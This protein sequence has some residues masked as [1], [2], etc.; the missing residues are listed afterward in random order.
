MRREDLLELCLQYLSRGVSIDEVLASHPEAAEL[1]PLLEAAQAAASLASSGVPR[2]ALVRSR[3]RMLQRAASLRSARPR[4]VGSAW[5]RPAL[6]AVLAAIAISFTGVG[7]AAA[8]SLPG[9]SL[10]AAKTVVEDV[11]LRLASSPAERLRLEQSYEARRVSEIRRLLALGRVVPVDFIGL[12]QD[13]TADSIQVSDIAVRLSPATLLEGDLLVGT[14][15]EVRGTT[16]TDGVVLA[17]EVR[18]KAFDLYGVIDTIEP[19]AW[20]I[21]GRVLEVTPDSV[22]EPGL[23]VGDPVVARVLVAEDGRLSLERVARFAPPTAEPSPTPTL[24]VPTTTPTPRATATPEPTE[25]LAPTD[26]SEED[27]PEVT[28]DAE[29]TDDHEDGG[30]EGQDVNFSGVV[31]SIGSSQWIIDGRVVLVDG[32]TEIRDDPEVGDT[33][34]VQARRRADGSLLAEKI[35]KD[36]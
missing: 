10:Y 4:R 16:Q 12:V 34:K 1:R 35:E 2:V 22:I 36:D 7:I 8:Q 27:S 21:A 5:L 29:A 9:D 11:M 6:A 23:A 14:E 13:A 18:L 24:P 19:A 30:E 17:D 3:T 28:Q 26:D 15:V 25:T 31:Q 33:V 20:V 32:S